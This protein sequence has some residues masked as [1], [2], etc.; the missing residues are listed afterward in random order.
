MSDFYIPEIKSIVIE[1]SL[2]R[3]ITLDQPISYNLYS[4]SLNRI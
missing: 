2:I 4:I 3:I 1:L